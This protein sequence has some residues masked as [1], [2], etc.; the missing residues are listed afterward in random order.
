[1]THLT[2]DRDSV[3]EFQNRVTDRQDMKN[4]LFLTAII[5]FCSQTIY[6]Q[7]PPPP[8]PP[9]VKNDRTAGV[10][11]AEDG[12]KAAFPVAPTRDVRTLKGAYGETPVIN[13]LAQTPQAVYIVAYTDLP[14]AIK[15]N[16]EREIQLQ[17]VKSRFAA[18]KNSRL[19]KDSEIKIG[20]YAGKEYVFETD[21][22]TVFTRGIIAKQR[23]FQITVIAQGVSSRLPKARKSVLETRVKSFFDSFAITDIPQQAES[24]VSLP[25]DFGIEIEDNIFSSEYLKFEI[26]LPEEWYFISDV[27]AESIK[28]ITQEV[29]DTSTVKKKD[30]L[31]LSIQN[32]KILLLMSN[33]EMGKDS[34]NAFF[35]IAAEKIIFPNFLPEEV[36]KYFGA[37][38]LEDYEKLTKPVSTNVF[39][40]KKFAWLEYFNA[41][42]KT[43]E[44]FYVAN[45]NGLALEF[46]LVYKDE[47]DLNKMLDALRTIQFFQE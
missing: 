35:T 14:V 40:N 6:L 8:A 4:F 24:S 46:F 28:E 26:E 17:G 11:P 23:F 34:V 22:L 3:S 42:D 41:Q 43:T 1:M 25:E 19:I 38:M 45:V 44:R 39:G 7:P 32:S 21:S 13:Y 15:E 37:N 29:I 18:L 47:E 20:E 31:A 2:A 33:E 27:P 10:A 36:A 5:L 9:P 16:L 12:F 30:E